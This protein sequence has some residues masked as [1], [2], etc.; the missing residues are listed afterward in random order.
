MRKVDNV[1]ISK[2][3]FEVLIIEFE[4]GDEVSGRSLFVEVTA[5]RSL[6][7]NMSIGL[8]TA[9]FLGST[10]LVWLGQETL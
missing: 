4:K 6:W 1:V 5:Y 10:L 7:S 9:I 2:M 8:S 3:G